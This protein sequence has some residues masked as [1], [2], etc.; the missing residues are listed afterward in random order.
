MISQINF[1]QLS[2]SHQYTMG[3]KK[4]GTLTSQYLRIICNLQGYDYNTANK[5][6]VA[7]EWDN[8]KHC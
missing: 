5:Y 8:G 4:S 2:L 1:C 6:F 3:T 7:L